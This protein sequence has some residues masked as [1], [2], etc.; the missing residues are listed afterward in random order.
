MA[1]FQF[2]TEDD[3]HT[4]WIGLR[5]DPESG[6]W[7]WSN[8]DE[9]RRSS[10]DWHDGKEPATAGKNCAVA[11]KGLGY[12]WEAENCGTIHPFMCAF[13]KP[14]C[15]PG[16]DYRQTISEADSVISSSCFRAKP[17]AGFEDDAGAK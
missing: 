4:I 17:F 3:S 5:R 16:Y 1:F 10:T 8:G 12:R 15:P 6:V 7:R 13:R 14:R 2:P 11:R 9:L